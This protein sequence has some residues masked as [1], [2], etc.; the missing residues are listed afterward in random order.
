MARAVI[1]GESATPAEPEL[2]IA[3]EGGK[4]Q[5][6][7]I[8]AIIRMAGR[9]S[10]SFLFH[11]NTAIHEDLDDVAQASGRGGAGKPARRRNHQV[12]AEPE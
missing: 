6:G 2:R 1:P 12:V 10:S 9:T 7:R 5:L 11:L 8:E 4:E 3:C